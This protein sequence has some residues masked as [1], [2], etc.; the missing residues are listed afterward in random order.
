MVFDPLEIQQ[1]VFP[2]WTV[3]IFS[4]INGDIRVPQL[5]MLHSLLYSIWHYKKFVIASL[6]ANRNTIAVSASTNHAKDSMMMSAGRAIGRIM[7]TVDRIHS[8]EMVDSQE[9]YTSLDQLHL[10][11]AELW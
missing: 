8:R 1:P 11:W 10:P 4:D 7:E 5:H 9:I 3:S 6:P 2:F